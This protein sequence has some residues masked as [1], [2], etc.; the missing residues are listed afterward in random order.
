M[1]KSHIRVLA[2]GYL[3]IFLDL[4]LITLLVSSFLCFLFVKANVFTLTFKTEVEALLSDVINTKCK[5]VN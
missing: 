5:L 1:G 2:Y 4:V 3:L